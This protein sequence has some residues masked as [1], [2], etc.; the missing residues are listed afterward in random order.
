MNDVPAAMVDEQLYRGTH[1]EIGELLADYFAGNVSAGCTGSEK[2]TIIVSEEEAVEEDLFNELT[3]EKEESTIVYFYRVDCQE[4]IDVQPF[5]DNLPSTISA[6]GNEVTLN[7]IRLNSREGNNGE[8]IRA[9]FDKYNVPS[10]DQ[11]VPFVFLSDRYLAG[12][13]EIEENLLQLL[14]QGH[15]QGFEF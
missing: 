5:I 8:R 1:Q 10:E 11:M 9:L 3:I 7:L 12:Q 13:K 6:N 15:G 14:E 4:C 2:D